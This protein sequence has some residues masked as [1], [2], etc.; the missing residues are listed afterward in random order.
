MRTSCV[1]TLIRMSAAGPQV[2]RAYAR[3]I[4]VADEHDAS[5]VRVRRI[6]HTHE[7]NAILPGH[8]LPELAVRVRLAQ[9]NERTQAGRDR[10]VVALL[11]W[12][13]VAIED[14]SASVEVREG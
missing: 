5:A 4:R 13:Q 9:T 6:T 12:V 7:A 10:L 8:V 2:R 3:R 1:P 11:V 14:A